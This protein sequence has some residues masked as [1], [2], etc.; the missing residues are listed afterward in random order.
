MPAADG[1]ALLSCYHQCDELLRRYVRRKAPTDADREDIVQDVY[2][3]LA[4]MPSL[5]GIRDLR[6][7]A[8]HAAK[9]LLR[10]RSRRA[11]KRAQVLDESGAEEMFDMADLSTEPSLVFESDETLHEAARV[12]GSLKA[13][14]RQAFLRYR[15]D[16]W[17][18]ADIASEMGISI[19]MVEKHLRAAC[20]ALRSAGIQAR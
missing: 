6:A 9:N 18:H 14:T 17:P 1:A 16:A 13:G 20:A 7:F 10:D 4:R 8:M 19:S 11:R 3:R 2:M 15:L 5:N 12:L